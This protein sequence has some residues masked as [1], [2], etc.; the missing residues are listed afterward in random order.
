MT[1]SVSVRRLCS[2]TGCFGIAVGLGGCSVTQTLNDITRIEYKTASQGRPLEVPPDL[3]SPRTDDR[4]AVPTRGAANA[5][6]TYS[7]YSRER[8]QEGGAITASTPGVLTQPP[9][10]R[11][12][13]DGDR[14]W[15][16]VD[17]PAAKVWPVVREFWVEAGFSLNKESPETGIIET[18]WA[19][20]RP[21][22]PDSF[23]RGQL[24]RFLGTIYT[25]GTRDKFRTRLE[26]AGQ[27][28]EV[29]VSHRGL[30]EQLSGPQKETTF[31]NTRPADP[32]LEAEFLRRIMLKLAPQKTASAAPAAGVAAAA[33]APD[34]AVLVQQDGMSAVRLQE[35]FDRSWRQVG[36]ALD[37]GGFTVEDRDRSKGT[38]FVRYVD[39]EQ[40]A[41][42]PGLLDKV[43]GTGPKKDLS[44]R[45]F[46]IVLSE[47][48]PGTSVSV[49]GEDGNLP[50][51]DSDRR[52]AN[53]IATLLRDQLR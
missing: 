53:Q 36:L 37:R 32:D 11:I 48:A 25:S 8:A 18:D 45:K 9:G 24:S 28:T 49:L 15:L 23:V 39:P 17:Q 6:T 14:R 29:Y 38:Y 4:Y 43:L 31:W 35:G 52:I 2:L 34:R 12:E 1:W 27:G 47:A 7:A 22:V 10:V 26:T 21:P 42:S 46:R 50:A 19:E 3:V 13:R 33:P 40:E 44:G 16:V 20:T 41:R 51:S 5:Q 30:V